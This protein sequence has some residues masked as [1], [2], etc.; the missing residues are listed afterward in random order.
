MGDYQKMYTNELKIEI[1]TR[2]LRLDG[3]STNP[4]I[5]REPYIIKTGL[6]DLIQELKTITNFLNEEARLDERIYCVLN[7][8]DHKSLCWCGNLNKFKRYQ[9]GYSE[10]CSVKCRANDVGWQKR[11]SDINLKKYGVTHIAQL[12]HERRVRSDSMKKRMGSLI[13]SGYD[14][15]TQ[16]RK[17]RETMKRL[18]GE[19]YNPGWTEKAIQTR[20]DNGNMVPVELL[21]EYRDYYRNV[22]LT[23]KKQKL[24]G[25]KNIKKRG[26][27]GKDYDAHHI[28]HI[29]SIYDGFMNDVPSEII[30]NICNLQCIPAK[31]NITKG[32]DS[33][34][35]IEELYEVTKNETRI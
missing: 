24:N 25:L 20:I 19:H 28:D 15:S 1:K 4:W 30:G 13:E 14:F 16:N 22:Q 9:L 11:V 26:V 5:Y 18:Y 12:A 34:M 17:A 23:T 32:N 35:T 33:W 29:V 21:D 6:V 2:L 3:L 31:D 10:F 8:I 27:L 7:D